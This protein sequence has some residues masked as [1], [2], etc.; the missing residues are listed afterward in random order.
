MPNANPREV[1][2]PANLVEAFHNYHN[3][4]ALSVSPLATLA[5][6]RARLEESTKKPGSASPSGA[7][8]AA[9]LK[10][11]I[12]S[13]EPKD[14]LLPATHPRRYA[15]EVLHQTVILG[16]SA[17]DTAARLY[18]SRS[19]LYRIREKA[20][21]D[22]CQ[23]WQERELQANPESGVQSPESRVRSPESRVETLES[24]SEITAQVPEVTSLSG[25]GKPEEETFSS[26][27]IQPEIG[28][29]QSSDSTATDSNSALSPQSS[30]LEDTLLNSGFRLVHVLMANLS[31]FN[32]LTGSVG[33]E[34]AHDLLNRMLEVMDQVLK[35]TNG[36]A[37]QWYD[38]GVCAFFGV[39]VSHED[40][41]V[42]AVRA[43]LR[44]QNALTDLR[45]SLPDFPASARRSWPTL[46]VGI[47][48]GRVFAGLTRST[49]A[50]NTSPRYT[51]TGQALDSA[52]EL[53]E[54]APPGWLLIDH[55]TYRQVRGLFE[56][57][58]LN[59]SGSGEL[60]NSVADE[61]DADQENEPVYRV[62]KERPQGF[63]IGVR[64]VLGLEVKMIGR[65][66][67]W[68][69]LLGL[70]EE[71]RCNQTVRQL[72]VVGAPGSGKSRLEHEF[73]KHLELQPHLT[74][75]WRGQAVQ[76][77]RLPY[78]PFAEMLGYK[79][80]IAED[81]SADKARARLLELCRS[82][83]GAE[84]PVW[85]NPAASLQGLTRADEMAHLLSVVL[86]LNWPDSPFLEVLA[87]ASP[88]VA[89]SQT[90]RAF[91]DLCE[92]VAASGDT[93][94]LVL[95][96]LHWAQETTLALW[97]YLSA[98][99]A[100]APILLL[101]L[102]RPE[103]YERK[104]DW[105]LGLDR[106]IR[107]DLKPLSPVRTRELIRHLLRKIEN[108]PETLVESILQVADGN[109]FYVE[110]IVKMLLENGVL[111]IDPEDG[112]WSVSR[113]RS[114]ES[115]VQ[116]LES[117][118]R[119]PESELNGLTF[120]LWTPDSGLR[121]PDSGWVVPSTVE[122]LIQARMDRLPVFERQLVGLAAVA[123]R[124]F[125]VEALEYLMNSPAVRPTSGKVG[126]QDLQ[127][128]LR[129][130]QQRE[131]ITRKSERVSTGPVSQ[132][133]LFRHSLLREIV[134][135]NMPQKV[136]A[137]LHRALA[138][139]LA[140]QRD[141]TERRS[142]QGTAVAI[143]EHYERAGLKRQAAL[144]YEEA[145]DEAR[146]AYALSEALNNYKKALDLLDPPETSNPDQPIIRNLTASH[147]GPGDGVSLKELLDENEADTTLRQ[148][149]LL[150]K[151]GKAETALGFYPA[152]L[153][154]FARALSLLPATE[155]ERRAEL[156]LQRGEIFWRQGAYSQGLQEARAAQLEL[157]TSGGALWAQLQ[158]LIGSFHFREGRYAE[159]E[160]TILE[161]L[162]ELQKLT[163]SEYEFSPPEQERNRQALAECY[164]NL[165]IVYWGRGDLEPAADYLE[166]ALSLNR[167]RN[168]QFNIANCLEFRGLTHR[169]SGEFK[170]AITCF[171][172]ARSIFKQLG[173]QQRTTYCNVNLG[174]IFWRMG[175]LDEAK[176]YYEGGL[177]IY[178]TLDAQ[179]GIAN[180][181]NS[182]ATIARDQGNLGLAKTYLE[183]SIEIN[184]RIHDRRSLAYN[185]Y[186]LGMVYHDQGELAQ[187]EDFYQ[188]SL[189]IRQEVGHQ[190]GIGESF[191]RLG[192]LYFDRGDL[193]RSAEYTE[194]SLTIFEKMGRANLSYSYNNL[195]R[196]AIQR[197]DFSKAVEWIKLAVHYSIEFGT[198]ESLIETYLNQGWLR[199]A[200]S[201]ADKETIG[202]FTG[203]IELAA[204]R[205]PLLIAS[206]YL[207]Q[208]ESCLQQGTPQTA[209]DLINRANSL[210][211][212]KELY[213]LLAHVQR[214]RAI[215]LRALG[216]KEAS[217]EAFELS[218]KAART[219]GQQYEIGLTE[220][221]MRD[222]KEE[223]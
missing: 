128:G 110:E 171:E 85:N 127:N 162:H 79:A 213:L 111:S 156:Q 9:E 107:L 145:G 219:S 73:R 46:K 187:A 42:R 47:G 134:Y 84:P 165:G 190:I 216:Q 93:L 12:A 54:I 22:L 55:Q 139:W 146:A 223:L 141:R 138:D 153:A 59:I 28:N 20:I 201:Q 121:T 158:A 92:K 103:L 172:Q 80:A 206:A 76:E 10:S 71:A 132:D 157:D 39:P 5:S 102:T 144:F 218:L 96:D 122:G 217:R 4:L 208:A 159:A 168:D 32:R 40:D 179:F 222:E 112:S 196:L 98:E 108:L 21:A 61:D 150:E 140:S 199:V 142:E 197:A 173:D 83:F 200:Q 181:Y 188:R 151:K 194:Q 75:Y 115:G 63:L 176:D 52:T 65:E 14:A 186:F 125:S 215:A 202:L 67:E 120:R 18:I 175:R 148:V 19:Q 95:E 117:G 25:Q 8:L 99:L 210:L 192:R 154:D 169:D 118:V 203:A 105:G 130:L 119:S 86:D 44:L 72:T 129:H 13:L 23:L 6:V 211:T 35:E 34:L 68:Q 36:Y 182:L 3:Q 163:A 137:P 106:H 104:P 91:A 205:Y 221:V 57:E 56:I 66:P 195:A 24:E 81:D 70:Y 167:Q 135:N 207:G 38:R 7:A 185:Y 82:L 48:S 17:T 15:Y 33:M 124:N 51:V 16:R 160:K 1:I 170:A 116:T 2:T 212:E 143:A 183:K 191:L 29:S 41:P 177:K 131:L 204:G 180:C 220:E 89:Q 58:R 189:Q 101:G 90:F 97:N 60:K 11:L 209:L 74:R 155:K 30:V 126:S 152:G 64:D 133:Y 161:A 87:K 164:R 37:N 26:L 178:Q 94:V 147:P 78:Q 69:M 113:V 174:I 49:T 77:G 43:A 109:P 198:D 31:G 62:L 88:Q 149:Q 184:N 123:G 27:P 114:P 45:D 214:L 50:G 100:E 166:E 136:R 53:V 193:N